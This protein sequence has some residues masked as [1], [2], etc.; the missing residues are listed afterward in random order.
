MS[1]WCNRSDV[2]HAAVEQLFILQA[3]LVSLWCWI[4]LFCVSVQ[5]H[6]CCEWIRQLKARILSPSLN[7]TCSSKKR[8]ELP[9]SAK[10]NSTAH[11]LKTVLYSSSSFL[12]VSVKKEEHEYQ[13]RPQV[14]FLAKCHVFS[15]FYDDVLVC[16]VVDPV[17]SGPDQ[18]GSGRPD[19]SHP[20]AAVGPAL[21]TQ[22]NAALH[23]RGAMMKTVHAYVKVSLIFHLITRP[24]ALLSES[25]C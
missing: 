24:A 12:F 14:A 11:S 15:I 5:L 16:L 25:P 8:K 20:A 13:K 18:R 10:E 6:C 17:S 2:H 22:R 3:P 21:Q 7:P 1:H 23:L 9:F 19:Q 4:V